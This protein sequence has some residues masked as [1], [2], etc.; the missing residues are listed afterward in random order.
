[1]TTNDRIKQVR[2][3]LALTQ[4]KFA[5]RIAI[6]IGFLAEMEL[7][8]KRVN[9]RIIR[10][11]GMEFKVS[12]HWLRT[13]KGAMYDDDANAN[14]AKAASLFKSLAREYQE[15]ALIQLNALTDLQSIK[16][17]RLSE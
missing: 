17:Q 10:L 16:S 2:H 12:E 11:I 8:N 4:A 14:I 6:S 13:G 15:C 9:E 5:E 7:G 1:M 3:A